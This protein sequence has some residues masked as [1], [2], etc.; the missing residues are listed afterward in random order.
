[1]KVIAT[2][3]EFSATKQSSQDLKRYIYNTLATAREWLV[4]SLNGDGE[5]CDLDI[6][7]GYLRDA[8]RVLHLNGYRN[9][10]LL[11][12]IGK[13]IGALVVRNVEQADQ[14]IGWALLICSAD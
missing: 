9:R 11:D 4:D 3:K 1:M 2:E 10:A 13:A 5:P 12:A 6:A 14:A 8:V 7:L